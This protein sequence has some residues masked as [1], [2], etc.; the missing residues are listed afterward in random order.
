M[1][2]A[3]AGATGFV[4]RALVSTLLDQGHEVLALARHETAIGPV[5]SRVVDIGD[6]DGVRVA[7]DGL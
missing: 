7:L 4:G 6:E 2:I 3:I 1:R 5:H